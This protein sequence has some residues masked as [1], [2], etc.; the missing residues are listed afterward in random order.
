MAGNISK[1]DKRLS[2]K[3][4]M[5]HP[6]HFFAF[7]CGAGLSPKAPGTMGSLAALPLA[8][9]LQHTNPLIY[10]AVTLLVTIAGIF[11]ADKSAQLIGGRDPAM[12]VIDEIAGILWVFAFFKMTV[13]TTVLGFTAFRFFDI[14]K[15]WPISY[16]DEK[17]EGGLGIMLDDL[18]AAVFAIVTVGCV[19]AG[20]AAC[21]LI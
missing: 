8:F 15:P 21:G 14:Q 5:A 6:I 3:D 19:M 2:F 13:V 12:I 20:L 4:M 9:A 11:I 17:I 18:V 7:G 1:Q 10:L 16:C